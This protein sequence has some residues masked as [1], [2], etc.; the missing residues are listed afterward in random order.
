METTVRLKTESIPLAALLKVAGVAETGGRA[1][2]LVQEGLV[3][4]NGT[5]ET[6]RGAQI[7]P[8]DVVTVETDPPF[9]IEV[10]T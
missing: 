5:S 6:R 4:V 8:G 2:H 3:F 7:R 10:A 9:R 1:K